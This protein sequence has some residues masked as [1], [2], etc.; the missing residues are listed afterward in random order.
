MYFVAVDIGGRRSQTA[1][2]RETL[3]CDYVAR[4]LAGA[5]AEDVDAHLRTCDECSNLLR[6]LQRDH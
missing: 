4:T 6:V 5:A 1:C 2:L 3:V